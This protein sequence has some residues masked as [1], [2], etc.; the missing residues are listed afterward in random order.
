VTPCDRIR[1][2]LLRTPRTWLVTGVAGFIGSNLLEALLDLGQN[3]VGLDN[4]T[5]GYRTN[6]REVMRTRS[7]LGTRF[8]L[9]EGDIRDPRCCAA[10]TTG[11]DYVLHHAAIGS[12]PR[13]LD[14]PVE[15]NDV[16][17]S[18]TLNLLA[19]ARCAAVRRVVF[20]SSSA[21]YGDSR[22]MP[23]P[24][25]ALGSPLS[26]YAASKLTNETYAAAFANCYGLETIAL[27]YFNV[28]GPRQD[29]NGSYA[30]V[31]PQWINALL[32]GKVCHIHGD[33]KTSRDFVTV[34]DV[35]QANL[36][37]AAQPVSPATPRVFNVGAGQRTSLNQL[38]EK[39]AAA[40]A[41]LNSHAPVPV[42]I[43]DDF[44]PGDIRHSQADISAIV[45]HLGY[46]PSEQLDNA[47][48]R[49]MAWYISRNERPTQPAARRFV[50]A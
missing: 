5:S 23:L 35:V 34:D 12:V 28:F 26:P 7:Q 10:A 15:V 42:C 30:A 49:T 50:N 47:L 27:R 40:L 14:D 9:I 6:I 17:V 2:E 21:V 32:N 31:I 38:F 11:V 24:E 45:E 16:N 36:L 18:G 46:V 41:Q 37:A 1:D 33:G 8:T 29:P 4:F 19:A 48:L 25:H 20:A 22:S 39:L 44:R 43:H 13:S 3:V